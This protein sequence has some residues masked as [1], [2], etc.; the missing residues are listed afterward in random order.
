MWPKQARKAHFTGIFHYSTLWASVNWSSTTTLTSIWFTQSMLAR[1][2]NREFKNTSFCHI[3]DPPCFHHHPF[4]IQYTLLSVL[5][6][7][8][9]LYLLRAEVNPNPAPPWLNPENYELHPP[10]KST[11]DIISVW[12]AG[13]TKLRSVLLVITVGMTEQCA[14]HHEQYRAL[15]VGRS[16]YVLQSPV[17][18]SPPS[19]THTHT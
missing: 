7:H 12:A 17:P 6:S 14:S 15:H 13:Q 4:N 10:T 3:V 19:T 16:Y 8:T 2:V 1:P 11:E 18:S 5:L 9:H